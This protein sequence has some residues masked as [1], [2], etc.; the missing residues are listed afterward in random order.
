MISVSRRRVKRSSFFWDV[1]ERRLVIRNRSSRETYWPN[2]QGPSSLG[3]L[4][5]GRWAL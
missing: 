4:D 2:L 5:S 3:L 1:T